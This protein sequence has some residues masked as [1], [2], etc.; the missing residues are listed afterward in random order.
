[1]ELSNVQISHIKQRLLVHESKRWVRFIESGGNNKGQV[2]E[3]FQKAVDGKAVGEP[4]CMSFMQYCIMQVDSIFATIYPEY[5]DHKSKIYQT[6]HC[7]TA[8][9]MS[10][11]DCRSHDPIEGA[12]TIWQKGSTSQGHTGAVA[13]YKEGDEYFYSVEGNTGPGKFV[14]REGDGV[15]LKKRPLGPVGNME[16]VGFLLTWGVSA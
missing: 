14:T 1:M 5:S 12:V 7:M 8:W 16:I 10:P 11:V 15:F 13:S 3:M 4:W 6:E 9:R 2:V